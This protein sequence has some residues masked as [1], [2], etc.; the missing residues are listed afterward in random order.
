LAR[1]LLLLQSSDWQFL[2]S[3]WHARDYAEQRFSEH[4]EKFQ[5]LVSMA[6]KSTKESLTQEEI[7]YLVDCEKSDSIFPDLDLT[8]FIPKN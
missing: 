4:A 8:W 6:Q 3:T 1:E 7:N 5:R 2:I